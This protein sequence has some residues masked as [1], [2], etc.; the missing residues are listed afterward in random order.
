MNRPNANRRPRGGRG[1]NQYKRNPADNVL[2]QGPAQAVTMTCGQV[3]GTRCQHQVGPPD[4]SHDQHPSQWDTQRRLR[5]TDCPPEAFVAAVHTTNDPDVRRLL[6]QHPNCPRAVLLTLVND[7]DP[8]VIRLLMGR[9]PPEPGLLENIASK[10]PHRLHEIIQNP[11]CPDYFI[12]LLITPDADPL[13]R[14]QAARRT[15]WRPDW[16]LHL[17]EDELPEVR[18]EIAA[19]E[20]CTADI[21]RH[22]TNDPDLRV[23]R[24]AQHRL[25]LVIRHDTDP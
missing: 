20:G 1:S 17:V 9:S 8:G 5:D 3:W 12:N 10:H 21:L 6:A 7:P 18:W 23:A 24:M 14:V 11:Y 22:L 4:Y 19:H 25:R 16:H 13:A 15:P 2:I